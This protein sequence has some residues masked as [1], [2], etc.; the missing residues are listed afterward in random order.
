MCGDFRSYFI[1]SISQG[2]HY[3]RIQTP[4]DSAP[5]PTASSPG[6]APA[7][8]IA[9]NEWRCPADRNDSHASIG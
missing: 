2:E 5:A 4:P 9:L 3:D 6:P 1:I 7:P 8:A